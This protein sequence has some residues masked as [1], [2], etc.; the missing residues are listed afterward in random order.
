MNFTA[1]N[2]YTTNLFPAANTKQGGQLVTEFNL[3]SLS[4]VDTDP[5]VEY[6]F[7][8]SFVHSERDFALSHDSADGDSILTIAPGRAIINGHYVE[9]LTPIKID[10]AEGNYR[11]VNNGRTP[12]R[13]T[14]TVG[15]R[16]FY[17]ENTT[18]IGSLDTDEIKSDEGQ[19]D[20]ESNYIGIQIVVLPPTEFILPGQGE[21]VEK[22]RK[23]ADTIRASRVDPDA[24]TA[25]LKL[26]TFSYSGG[27]IIDDSIIQNPNK[28]CYFDINRVLN[29]DSTMDSGYFSKSGLDANRMYTVATKKAGTSSYAELCDSTDS[30]MSWDDTPRTLGQITNKDNKEIYKQYMTSF[31]EASFF[32]TDD[33]ENVF[34]IIPHKQPDSQNVNSV[35]DLSY[36]PRVLSIPV[37]DIANGSPGIVNKRYTKGVINVLNRI[38]EFYH[39]P[40]G[41]QLLYLEEL[42]D[43][44]DLPDIS[45]LPS[46]KKVGDYIIVAQDSTFEDD[47]INAE[48]NNLASTMYVLIPGIVRSVAPVNS[49]PVGFEIH[50]KI[51]E[52]G[53]TPNTTD[54]NVYNGKD[55]FDFVE[56]SL[57]GEVGRDYFTVH[58]TQNGQDKIQYYVVD[59][60]ESFEY[61]EP[62]VVTNT[63][64]LA[65]E[66]RIGGFLNIPD[67]LDYSDMGYVG[68]DGDGHLVVKDYE[69]LRSGLLAYS[70]GS[71]VSLVGL[72]IDELQSSLDEFVNERI[73]FPNTEANTHASNIIDVTIEIPN[74]EGE[75]TLQIR[76]I[77]SRFNTCVFLHIMGTATNDVTLEIIDCEKIMIDNNIGPSCNINLYR[78]NLWYDASVLNRLD[79]ISG[80]GLWYEKFEEYDKDIVVDGMTVRE[81][82]A[83]LNTEHIDYFSENNKNDIHYQYALQSLTFDTDGHVIG[84]GIYI[85]DCTTRDQ[86]PEGKHV[87]TA[88]LD[89]PQGDGLMYPVTRFNKPLKITGTFVSAYKPTNT[90]TNQYY[91]ANISFS[92]VTEPYDDIEGGTSIKGYV[93]LYDES[94][95]IDAI[96]G[97]HEI[98]DETTG[99]GYLPGIATKDF[100]MFSGGVIG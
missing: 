21:D 60:T 32:Q 67:E 71:D 43:R 90:P 14:L 48:L 57:R 38:N 82:N 64:P 56:L 40:N 10:I 5:N 27:S 91:I 16:M 75:H 6:M 34:F 72:S 20:S 78:S 98:I 18:L 69:L 53:Q 15:I 83:V 7:G 8:H 73:A 22:D 12:L 62:I 29:L 3:R 39:L 55:Y 70:L 54:S 79:Y 45:E 94:C 9:S 100:H 4:S 35:N 74:E 17:A 96:G 13:G 92:A 49:K 44:K 77:D 85:R 26:G 58:Y 28:I 23:K 88:P 68:L 81:V 41:K 33:N 99:K 2:A 46:D 51:L 11:E 36:I 37:A 59:R 50:S 30:M 63:I 93:T 97:L 80:L 47:D 76:G 52:E 31:R 84:L 86:L 66:S 25:H 95:A 24:I 1:F 87:I 42:K 19:S 65:Q 89:L 61:S